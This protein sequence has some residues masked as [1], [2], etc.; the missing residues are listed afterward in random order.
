MA[1]CHEPWVETRRRKAAK[2]ELDIYHLLMT[3]PIF[4]A[5]Y[6]TDDEI[7]GLPGDEAFRLDGEKR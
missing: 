3:H 1:S 2:Q 7:A 6:S 5:D 4:E